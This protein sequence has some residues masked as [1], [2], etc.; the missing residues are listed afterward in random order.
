M[1]THVDDVAYTEIANCRVGVCLNCRNM[2]ID[3]ISVD[4]T[5][6]LLAHSVYYLN[7]YLWYLHAQF[8][9]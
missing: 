1:V 4:A 2:V 6:I 7:S 5:V 3:Q 8:I 9:I